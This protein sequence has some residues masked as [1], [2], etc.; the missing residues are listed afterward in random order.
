MRRADVLFEN[1]RPGT[2]DKYGLGPERA[3]DLNPGLVYCSVTGFG[4]GPGAALPGY[5]LLVQAVGGLMAVVKS[6][7]AL[8]VAAS[9]AAG[10]YARA[11]GL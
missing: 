8:P 10:L 6:I 3:Q 7:K 11:D 2:M 4:D 5:D 1:F 9:T